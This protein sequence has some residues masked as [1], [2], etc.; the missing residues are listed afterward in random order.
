[1]IVPMVS[2]MCWGWFYCCG[3]CVNGCFI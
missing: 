3:N 1:M 2:I